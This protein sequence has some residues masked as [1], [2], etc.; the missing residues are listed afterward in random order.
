[1][2]KKKSARV[3]SND[4][5][6]VVKSKE[7]ILKT[8]WN[9]LSEEGMRGVTIEE[10]A[11]RSGVA[12]TTIYRHWPNRTDLLIA[13]CSRVEGSQRTPDEGKLEKNLTVL[14]TDLAR[15]L[16]KAKWASILPSVI[17]TAER[18]SRIAH[19]H[20]SL[21]KQHA[22]PF[23]E[24]IERAKKTGELPAKSDATTITAQLMGPLFYRRYF[25]RE[26]LD[27][28]FIKSLITSVLG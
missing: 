26:G 4:D 25:S 22:R 18:D 2:N 27:H 14:M 3:G 17:D 20:G 11:K 13:A 23:R 6:R 10:V 24:V 8:T 15:M 28:Q 16:Q 1:M 5:A 7:I 9:L 21:Q 12:K 19:L